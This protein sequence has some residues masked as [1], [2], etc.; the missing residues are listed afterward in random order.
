MKTIIFDFDGTLLDSR[1]RHKLV[2]HDILKNDYN[3]LLDEQELEKFF[4]YKTDGNNTFS[5]LTKKLKLSEIISRE[6]T[7]KWIKNIE[8]LHYLKSDKLYFDSFD[9]VKELSSDYKFIMISARK[10]E[11]FLIKQL[12]SHNLFDFFYEI[13]CVNPFDAANS[14]KNVLLNLESPILFVGDT[15]ADYEAALHFGIPFYALN[16][17]FRSKKFWDLKNIISHDSLF[18]I[19]NY[20]KK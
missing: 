2:L 16:R 15:E 17:G 3:I 14:K 6:V 11:S 12:K 4:T 7:E 8:S 5:Y 18:E 13:V 9:M 10:S 20:I 1:K 19:K